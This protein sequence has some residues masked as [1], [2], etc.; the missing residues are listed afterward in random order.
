[1]GGRKKEKEASKSFLPGGSESTIG[2]DSEQC[3]FTVAGWLPGEMWFCLEG[4][5]WGRLE[6]EREKG[7]WGEKEQQAESLQLLVFIS[8]TPSWCH[9]SSPQLILIDWPVCWSQV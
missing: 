2:T 5:G 9:C 7:E 6:R 4:R 1:M 3:V 8:R